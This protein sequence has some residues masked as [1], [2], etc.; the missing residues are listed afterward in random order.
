MDMKEQDG[1]S[2]IEQV[3]ADDNLWRAY[4]KVRKN[5]GA[6]GVDGITVY[7]LKGHMEKYL[8]APEAKA[9]GW[10]LSTTTR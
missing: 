2:L 9:K 6:P 5:K 8:P 7:Q 3:I 4:K 10:V 1:I